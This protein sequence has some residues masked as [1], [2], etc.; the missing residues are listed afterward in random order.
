[1]AKHLVACLV[2]CLTS[3]VSADSSIKASAFLRDT[4]IALG[5]VVSTHGGDI[6]QGIIKRGNGGRQ[7]SPPTRQQTTTEAAAAA[8]TQ[9]ISSSSTSSRIPMRVAYQGEPGAYSEKSTRELLGDNVIAVGRPNF[10]ACFRAVVGM[11]CDYA[12]LPV[13]NSLGGSIHE[14]YDLMLRYDLTIVAEHEFRV[15]HCML[16]KAGVKKEDIKY[17]ISHPQ[18]LAQCDNYLRQLGITPV[19]SY[20]TAGSAKMIADAVAAKDGNLGTSTDGGERR[21]LP[22]DCT[23][24]NTCAIASDLAGRIYG[25][26]CLADGIQDDDSNFT[27]FLLLGRKGIT[28]HLTPNI[29]AKTSIVFTLPNQSG[30]LYKALACFSLRD[31]DFSKIE[32]RPTSASLLSFLKFRSQLEGRKAKGNTSLPRFRYCFYLDFLANELDEDAQNAMHH[33]REQADFC[34]VL[35]SYP[36]K[37]RLVGPVFDSAEDLKQQNLP[38]DQISFTHLPSD[39]EEIKKLRIGIVGFGKYGQFLSKK[40]VKRHYVSCTDILDKSLDASELGVEYVPAF[41]MTAFLRDLDVVVLAMPLI[42]LE[43]TVAAFPKEQLRGK[44][45]VEVCALSGHPKI[46]LLNSLPSDV[47]ILCSTPMFGPGS[48]ESSSSLHTSW[49]SLPLVYEKVR[50]TD[51]TRLKAFLSIFEQERCKLVEM[52]AEQIDASVADAVFVTHLTGR[53]LERD[54][55][56]P[57]FVASKEYEAL[58]NIADMTATDESFD[59]FYGLYKYNPNAKHLLNRMRSNLAKVECQ[60]AAKEAYLQ[61]KSEMQDS[62]RL[63]LIA[64]AKMLLQEVAKSSSLKPLESSLLNSTLDKPTTSSQKP[65]GD[66]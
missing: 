27:R 13:E 48:S 16:V 25:L 51:L 11:E 2:L 21:K 56:P 63:M 5:A 49:D 33:L 32:S 66:S 28:Q 65:K 23:P 64:E 26:E 52:K 50:I 40:F 54:L 34:R 55:L 41:D 6:T 17:A 4:K 57:T 35:G 60:L 31:I 37:S 10:E 61:A 7:S 19:P 9:S 59:H 36:Q 8:V 15:H 18:A 47:D 58:L 42:E 62:D 24:E 38:M 22:R 12:C 30:A 43:N 29:P 53:L 14:N 46:V 44:L 3:H 45:I 1:M 39:K 20:D